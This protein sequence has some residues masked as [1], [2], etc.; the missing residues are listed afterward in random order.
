MPQVALSPLDLSQAISSRTFCAG[1]VLL[2]TIQSG[3]IVSSAIGSKSRSMSY[4]SL[5]TIALNT[6]DATLLKLMVYPSGAART[7]RPTPIV[8]AAPPTFLHDHRLSERS[9]H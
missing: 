8:P 3:E 2:A 4:C 1:T 5:Y 7:T 9:V 6:C